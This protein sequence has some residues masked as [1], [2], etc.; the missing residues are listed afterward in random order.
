M[1]NDTI[2]GII[3]S[4]LF[5]IVVLLVSLIRIPFICNTHY[6]V[7][8]VMDK[9]SKGDSGKYLIFVRIGEEEKVYQNTD[10]IMR[11]KFN[12]SD[13]YG[14]LKIGKSYRFT[15]IG[16]RVPFLSWYQNIIWISEMAY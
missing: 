15:L 1:S 4:I 8:T 3:V 2:S 13:I 11:L 12:S 6:E 9:V 10:E 16:Y 14:K 7:A 5:G